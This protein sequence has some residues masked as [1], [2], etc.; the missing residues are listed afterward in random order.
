MSHVFTRGISNTFLWWATEG[1]AMYIAEQFECKP[2]EQENIDRFFVSSFLCNE[3]YKEFYVAQGY[4][5]ARRLVYFAVT[6]KGED[7][8]MKFLKLS[9]ETATLEQVAQILNVG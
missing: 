9:R 6:E 2:L 7:V 1:V 4:Q 8:L 5:I 3:P